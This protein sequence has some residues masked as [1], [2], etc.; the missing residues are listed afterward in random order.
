MDNAPTMQ[1]ARNL[2]D[3]FTKVAREVAGIFDPANLEPNPRSWEWDHLRRKTKAAIVALDFD[4]FSAGVTFDLPPDTPREAVETFRLF[5][6]M[7]AAIKVGII[8]EAAA[9]NPAL[10]PIYS[11]TPR[12]MEATLTALRATRLLLEDAVK[13]ATEVRFGEAPQ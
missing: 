6:D 5:E 4:H 7:T 11:G 9:R 13:R 2:L 1:E 3:D 8:L 10:A 12:D